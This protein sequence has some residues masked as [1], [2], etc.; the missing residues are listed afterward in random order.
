VSG[1]Q[2]EIRRYYDF[3]RLL[4]PA[5]QPDHD[6]CTS[7]MMSLGDKGMRNLVTKTATHSFVM[8]NDIKYNISKQSKFL[9]TEKEMDNSNNTFSK[10][11]ADS[12]TEAVHMNFIFQ[13][14][15]QQIYT[16]LFNFEIDMICRRVKSEPLR[17]HYEK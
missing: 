11:D 3:S 12:L 10:L 6:F 5:K 1:S 17:C 7:I 14:G 4:V 15:S 8:L 16:L 13:P 2:K 9:A